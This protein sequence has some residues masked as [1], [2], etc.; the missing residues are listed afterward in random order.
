MK[1]KSW[2][3]P[4]SALSATRGSL[5]LMR[6]RTSDV[7]TESTFSPSVADVCFQQMNPV[8]SDINFLS[9]VVAFFSLGYI[10]LCL[11]PDFIFQIFH[12]FLLYLF[13]ICVAVLLWNFSDRPGI[14]FARHC[15]NITKMIVLGTRSQVKDTRSSDVFQ[16]IC[17][18][19]VLWYKLKRH[20]TKSQ[21]FLL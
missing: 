11:I 8:Q 13:I 16:M 15:R 4:K 14:P 5:N 1:A 12:I 17:L 9:F 18:E 10:A 3:F 20:Q 7:E 19:Q 21:T 2:H 6:L